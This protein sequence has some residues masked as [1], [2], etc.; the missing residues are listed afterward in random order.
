MITYVPPTV[1]REQSLRNIAIFI[2]FITTLETWKE[3]RTFKKP[4]TAEMEVYLSNHALPSLITS[5]L[6]PLTVRQFL[7]EEDEVRL[8]RR[9]EAMQHDLFPV[10]HYL[11]QD[12]LEEAHKRLS[13][14]YHLITDLQEEEVG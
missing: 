6:G 9:L 14:L 3:F 5:G 7:K 8:K 13:K 11:C 10:I 4:E 1:D 12:Q 2:R